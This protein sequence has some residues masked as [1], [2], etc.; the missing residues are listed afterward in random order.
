MVISGSAHSRQCSISSAASSEKTWGAGS[1]TRKPRR[2]W[3]SHCRFSISMTRSPAAGDKR[4]RPRRR[5]Q[6][7]STSAVA[8][9]RC[10]RDELNRADGRKLR[11]RRAACN[12]HAGGGVAATGCCGRPV[13][14]ANALHCSYFLGREASPESGRDKPHVPPRGPMALN[15]VP[16]DDKYDLAKSRIFVTGYQ[17]LVRLTLMQ[18]ERDRRAGLNTAGYV[19]GYRGSPLGGLDQQF[20]RAANV[21]MPNDV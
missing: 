21:L 20:M 8:I 16:L 10:C 17:A 6:F 2:R 7:D 15:P 11:R 19:T 4:R 3:A 12:F 13:S 1:S 9:C 5:R 18:K 14:I